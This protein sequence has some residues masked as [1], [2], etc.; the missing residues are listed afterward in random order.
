MPDCD[1]PKC[2]E[3]MKTALQD[4]PT[5][6]DISDMKKTWL[7]WLRWAFGIVA[8]AILPLSGAALGVWAGQQSDSLRYAEKA[9]VTSC[10]IRLDRLE[11]GRRNIEE[12]VR[13]IK[14][15]LRELLKITR[16]ANGIPHGTQ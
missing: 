3:E 9:D 13:E 14:S 6:T 2:H 7:F 10:Q 16:T 8:V 12:D 1:S 11:E 15:S 4:R 5:W